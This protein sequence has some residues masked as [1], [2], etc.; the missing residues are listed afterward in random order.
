LLS[1]AQQAGAIRSGIG[2]ADLVRLLKGAITSLLDASM[3][4]P[5]QATADLVFTVLA[6]GLRPPRVHQ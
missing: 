5:S 1:R 2:V 4:A 6:D 3:E